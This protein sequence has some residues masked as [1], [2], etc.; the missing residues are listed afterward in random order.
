MKQKNA[1]QQ[2]SPRLNIFCKD[3][4]QTQIITKYKINKKLLQT[5]YNVDTVEHLQD[6]KLK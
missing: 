5:D 6:G 4:T 1:S 3:L 2:K